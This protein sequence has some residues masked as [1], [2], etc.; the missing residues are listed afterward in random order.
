L[1]LQEKILRLKE[2]NIILREKYNIGWDE[3]SQVYLEVNMYRYTQID[4][5]K[6]R[7]WLLV[8]QK[9]NEQSKVMVA[10]SV[11][12]LRLWRIDGVMIQ[13]R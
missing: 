10:G 7:E 1:N 9:R 3:G 4:D 11:S 8:Y 5:I 6:S 13:V 12:K 2:S